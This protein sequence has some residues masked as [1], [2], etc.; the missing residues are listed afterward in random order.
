MTQV[1]KVDLG[2]G[3][4]FKHTKALLDLLRHLGIIDN[5]KRLDMLISLY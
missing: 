1:H 2:G 3:A 5:E 4:S